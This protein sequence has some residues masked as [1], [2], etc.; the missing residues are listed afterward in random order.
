M[1]K[2]SIVV[3]VIVLCSGAVPGVTSALAAPEPGTVVDH[4]G[5]VVLLRHKAGSYTP[6][7]AHKS[8]IPAIYE[9]FAPSYPKGLYY[10][11]EGASLS[12]P[13]TIHGQYWQAAA[14][15][16]AATATVK[17]VDVAAGYINGTNKV[18]I[19]LY[20]D[21]S[22]VPGKELWSH[23]TALPDF[24]DCCAIVALDDKAKVQVVAGTQYWVVMT[25]PAKSADLMAA[26][27][28][29]VFDQVD[30]GIVA[31][32]TGTGWLAGSAQTQYAFGVYGK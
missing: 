18:T 19:G 9:N 6:P 26:W 31:I 3:R 10:A 4:G 5:K 22:G 7:L 2:I 16:P 23:A 21:A 20:A 15:T 25:T 27:N 17:E 24:G 1:K 28:L 12:G 13:H 14:F 11:A 32:N 29:N 8:K 30:P